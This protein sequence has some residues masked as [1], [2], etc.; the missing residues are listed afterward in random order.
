M[1][2]G[3]KNIVFHTFL[4]KILVQG[5]REPFNFDKM[6]KLPK[7]LE[8]DD[9]VKQMDSVMTPEYKNDILNNKKSVYSF[10]HKLLGPRLKIGV[11]LTFISEVIIAFLAPLLKRLITWIEKDIDHADKAQRYEGVITTALISLVII[12]SKLSFLA[13]RY[14][15]LQAQIHVQ[16]FA[17]VIHFYFFIYLLCFSRTPFLV[18]DLH[19]CSHCFN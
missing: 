9:I 3:I 11:V 10:Y 4:N 19:F 2:S 15:I 18:E 16:A 12:V 6:Y 17:Y 1:G 14:Y 5:Q 7:Y 13:S 8:F